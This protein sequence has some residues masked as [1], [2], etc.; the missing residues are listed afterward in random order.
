MGEFISSLPNF[1]RS[2][3]QELGHGQPLAGDPGTAEVTATASRAAGP[4]P[5][6]GSRMRVR[7]RSLAST[8]N[9]RFLSPYLPGCSPFCS[10]DLN[11]WACLLFSTHVVPRTFSMRGHCGGAKP[12]AT[13][14]WSSANLMARAVSGTV[15]SDGDTKLW[16][17]CASYRSSSSEK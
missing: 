12:N 17:L 5:W 10:H 3:K 13:F 15:L 11:P 16:F 6:E 14:E 2:G 4:R 7:G 9:P 1:R 8:R